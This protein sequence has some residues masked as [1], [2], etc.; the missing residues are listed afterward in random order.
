MILNQTDRTLTLVFERT[1][2]QRLS[3]NLYGFGMATLGAVLSYLAVR[4]LLVMP[5]TSALLLVVLFTAGAGLSWFNAATALLETDCRTVFDLAARQVML[6]RTGWLSKQHGPVPFEEI[7]E[8]SAREGFIGSGRML[9]AK[10]RLRSGAQWRIGYD[11]IWVRPTTVSDIPDLLQKVRLA[12]GL[13][14]ADWRKA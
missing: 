1:D 5:N 4:V 13:P 11:T 8:L 7:A 9:I 2:W 6:V 14:G 10:L 12:T 3:G